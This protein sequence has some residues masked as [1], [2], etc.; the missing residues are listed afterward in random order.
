MAEHGE[1]AVVE[2]GAHQH[3]P[4]IGDLVY[5]GINFLIFAFAIVYFLRGPI[6][7]YFRAR[8]AHI[9]NSLAAGA[10][11]REEAAAL[12]AQ[13]DRE[14]ADLPVLRQQMQNDLRA[15]AERERD[16]L[17]ESATVAA[18]RIRKDAALAADH[19]F[20]QARRRIRTEVVGGAISEATAIVRQA[21][22]PEDQ[23]RFVRDFVQTAGGRQ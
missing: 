21:L 16:K 14:L 20:E 18:E 6:R 10:K 11:A 9:R 17:V 12:R 19:E 22:R 1:H 5:P 13:I 15:T 23:A 3:Q 8:T 7:E 2:H 4:G